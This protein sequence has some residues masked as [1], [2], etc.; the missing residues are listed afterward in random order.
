MTSFSRQTSLLLEV[1][2]N[3]KE[4]I[5]EFLSKK[6]IIGRNPYGDFSRFFDRA[7]EELLVNELRARGYKGTIV[8]EELGINIGKSEE[9]IYIDPLDGSLNVARGIK[10]YCVAIAYG[11]GESIDDIKS[12]VVWDIPNNIFYIAESGK[13]SYRL[14]NEILERIS[15]MRDYDVVLIDVGFTTCERCLKEIVDMGTFRRLGSI[16]ISSI[17]VAEG[18]F[19]GVFDMGK[20]KATDVAAPYLIIKE[21][22]G[23]VFVEPK[24]ISG[25]P[26]VKLIAAKNEEIFSKLMEIY[27]QYVAPTCR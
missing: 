16:I 17:R 3:N 2:D 18:V 4:K 1:I 13:G 8:G 6:E 25:N 19:E 27:K 24:R 26:N 7:I 22:G 9:Y 20:L 11:D 10:Y 5:I 14:N 23:Y 21:A 12:A 15:P